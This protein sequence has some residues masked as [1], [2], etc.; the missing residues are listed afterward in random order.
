MSLPRVDPSLQ[1]FLGL[2]KSHPE[3][4]TG[5]K[6][7]VNSEAGSCLLPEKQGSYVTVKSPSSGWT[8]HPALGTTHAGLGMEP[9]ADLPYGLWVAY[10]GMSTV[11]VSTQAVL[12]SRM[13]FGGF[14]P[15]RNSSLLINTWV[16]SI[17]INDFW[18][19]VIDGFG[20]S[21]PSLF[22]T[23]VLLN[24]LYRHLFYVKVI[25]FSH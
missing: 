22:S 5:R 11:A 17:W 2:G 9:W 8:V 14:L 24:L 15:L 16:V 25:Y 6:E 3:E 21:F 23:V 20:I 12:P 7:E 18:L 4:E 10:S 13:V 19:V 1:C